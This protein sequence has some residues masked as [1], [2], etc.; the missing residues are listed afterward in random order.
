MPGPGRPAEL[1]TPRRFIPTCNPRPPTDKPARAN[2]S[3]HA[4]RH[5]KKFVPAKPLRGRVVV[6]SRL[7]EF[8]PTREKDSAGQS[9]Y[10]LRQFRVA[11]T[12]HVAGSR[13]FPDCCES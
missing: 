13:S 10:M 8:E 1:Y 12:H 7:K 11:A 5:S 3:S 4:R 2:R 9:D 6:R